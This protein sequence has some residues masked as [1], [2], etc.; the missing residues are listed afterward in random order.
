MVT[1]G[2]RIFRA[3]PSFG[4]RFRNKSC[5]RYPDMSRSADGSAAPCSG[6]SPSCGSCRQR[7]AVCGVSGLQ[8]PLSHH[9]VPASRCG[10]RVADGQTLFFFGPKPAAAGQYN[11]LQK[12]AY[13]ST[14]GS[15]CCRCSRAL[16]CSSP[17][18]FLGWRFYSEGF[19]SPASGTSP[20]CADSSPS[21]RSPDHGSAAWL[22]EFLLHA[23]RLETRTR[24]PG[25]AKNR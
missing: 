22:V 8:G 5:S 4:R 12:L 24:V 18:S 9:A 23:F 21:S 19:T 2:L 13:T 20:R 17:H 3:F 11:P 1:S 7:R 15:A 14:L 6:I 25:V 16:S 10:R